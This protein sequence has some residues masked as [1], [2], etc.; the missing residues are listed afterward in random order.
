MA[1]IKPT[2]LILVDVVK[3]LA[4]HKIKRTGPKATRNKRVRKFVREFDNG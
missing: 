3:A 2:G 1:K 4:I